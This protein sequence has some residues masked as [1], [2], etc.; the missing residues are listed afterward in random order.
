MRSAIR[1][2]GE[3]AS[4]F[5]DSKMNAAVQDKIKGFPKELQEQ[6]HLARVMLPR[7]LA[8]VIHKNP[9]LIAPGVQSFYT[10]TTQFKVLSP[11]A[12]V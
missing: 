11:N 12:S 2:E 3:T 9:Q 4:L 7:L 10:R 1:S 6:G 8:Q 5:T